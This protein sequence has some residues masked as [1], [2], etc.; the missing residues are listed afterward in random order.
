MRKSICSFNYGTYQ[1]KEV[2]KFS[3]TPAFLCNV[4][5]AKDKVLLL[6]YSIIYVDKRDNHPLL[7][8]NYFRAVQHALQL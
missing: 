5:V 4:T 2:G 6:K 7:F 1:V 3:F 8:L